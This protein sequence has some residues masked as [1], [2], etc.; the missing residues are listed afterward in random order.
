MARV[1][2]AEDTTLAR[3]VAVKFLF[4][5][6]GRKRELMVD[7]FL[8]EA[9]IAA[10]VRHPN[11]VDLIDFGTTDGGRPYMVMELLE[12]EPLEDRIQREPPL[13]LRALVT[14]ASQIL[15]GLS[16][17][18]DA[19]IV[20]RDLKPDN[21]F[22]Q[23]DADRVR[24]KL[25]D[26]GVSRDTNP[27]SGRR[28]ALTT[29]DGHLVG[30]PEYMSPE[31]ARGVKDVDWRTDL[32]SVGVI[33]YE[34]MTGV[35]PYEAEAVG[36]LIIDIVQGGAPPVHAIRPDVGPALGEVVARAMATDRRERFQSAREMREAL[37]AAAEQS[38]DGGVRAS[39]P[40]L[41]PARVL[42]APPE[43]PPRAV[44]EKSTFDEL[45]IPPPAAAL[46]SPRGVPERPGDAP[47]RGTVDEPAP[48]RRGRWPWVAAALTIPAVAVGVWAA[49]GPLAG[50]VES[51]RNAAT[52]VG[53]GPSVGEATGEL[54]RP[55]GPASEG[56][57]AAE[58]A[59][60]AE[61]P[62]SEGAPVTAA[63]E[64]TGSDDDAPT[65]D[66]SGEA[67]EPTVTVS[68]RGLPR[69][70]RVRVDGAW[71]EAERGAIRL[72]RDGEEHRLLVAD[73]RQRVWRATH[74]A[75]EDG[76]YRVRLRRAARARAA[77]AEATPTEAAPAP[78][79]HRTPPA[80]E[81]E[82][83]HEGVFRDLDY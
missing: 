61:A 41:V 52:A 15:D 64:T 47:E 73:H 74:R 8:R 83:A 44:S 56:E 59:L 69:R 11:V 35:L 26:F 65:D 31:Q 23:T 79:A 3:P 12:G 40:M 81:P 71:V 24:P 1:Y 28:S 76:D 50:R 21:V 18:H 57:A 27:S 7:R 45:S 63:A 25:L 37:L 55:T 33:L 60:G 51:P 58:D 22:L 78:E 29:T 42:R 39:L 17:V 13:T 66:A 4:L 9:R 34:A 82:P 30:T 19:G 5:R 54:V 6:E 16:A 2:R 14:L 36:D 32:Y 68:L 43:H 10:A 49:M 46:A 62:S 53:V 38:L 77:S 20:H 80:A 70:A 67:A 72:P 75:D 48:G